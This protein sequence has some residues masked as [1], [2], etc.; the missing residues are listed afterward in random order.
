MRYYSKTNAKHV[1]SKKKLF[2]ER[3]VKVMITISYYTERGFGD[4]IRAE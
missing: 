2:L 3:S 4:R 1:G